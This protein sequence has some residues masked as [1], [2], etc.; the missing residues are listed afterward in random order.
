MV[1]SF[2]TLMEWSTAS[3][4]GAMK[5]RRFGCVCF[6]FGFE[7]KLLAILDAWRFGPRWRLGE[8]QLPQPSDGAFAGGGGAP[9]AAAAPRQ[10]CAIPTPFD[11]DKLYN[12]ADDREVSFGGIG[13]ALLGISSI[14]RGLKLAE[15]VLGD[16]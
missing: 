9:I 16:D 1:N 4:W 5:L 3:F 8:Q 12:L 15:Q 2:Q 13:E 7:K 6:E 11:A 10:G 14:L